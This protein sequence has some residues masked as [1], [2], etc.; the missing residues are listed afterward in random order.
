MTAIGSK[1]QASLVSDQ[2][3]AVLT[4]K[5]ATKSEAFSLA[6]VLLDQ[7]EDMAWFNGETVRI[8]VSRAEA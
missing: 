5:A 1:W 7:A 6:H 3:G 8:E 4:R 2:R